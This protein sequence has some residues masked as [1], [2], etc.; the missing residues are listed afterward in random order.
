[1]VDPNLLDNV[2]KCNSFYQPY[3]FPSKNNIIKKQ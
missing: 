3:K 1:M 2:D